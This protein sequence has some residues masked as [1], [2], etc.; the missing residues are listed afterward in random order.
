ML[1]RGWATEPS[2][3][4]LKDLADKRA[5][6]QKHVA[7]VRAQREDTISKLDNIELTLTRAC[8]DMG[9]LYGSVTQQDIAEALVELGYQV[10]AREVRLPGSIK[11]VD[12]YEVLVKFDTDLEAT[13][14]IH[15]VA[16][17]E[18]SE[19]DRDEMEF[20]N[21]GNLIE[22]KAEAPKASGGDE[23]PAAEANAAE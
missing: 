10:K 13:M 18:I 17:R 14:K 23:Q 6:A 12:V 22:K 20:D 8:N 2:E 11:R 15:V 4:L 7:E 19:D 21:E 16:D 9:H 1:P 3:E 5:E